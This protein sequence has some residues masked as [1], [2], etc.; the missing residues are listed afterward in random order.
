M[1]T[2]S[3]IG[4]GNLAHNLGLALLQAGYAIEKVCSRN[5]EHAQALA[6]KL[7]CGFTDCISDLNKNSDYLL[8]AVKDDVIVELLPQLIEFS[9]ILI[10]SS[11]S[12]PIDIF[13]P[14]SKKY[15][16]L[17]P[18]QS[19]N[20]NENI[21][22]LNIPIFIEGNNEE[23]ISAIFNLANSISDEVL[24]LESQKRKKVHIAA[25]FVN[26]FS[27]HLYCMAENILEKE[28]IG[29]EVM[30]PLIQKLGERLMHQSPKQ[31]QT[32]PAKRKDL[33]IIEEHLSLLEN[34]GEM[35]KI[36]EILSKSIL[37]S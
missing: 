2:I 9:S 18:L 30:R 14:Y 7:N 29:F 6:K 33:K 4:S 17:Y 3:I 19:F 34:Q 27:N 15:G 11:G 16:V 10:H 32:G 25:I 26:N 35:Q 37:N 12:L 23:C 1:K 31:L 24:Y 5:I 28:H 21:D 22:F 36:Y 13:S 8:I 20:K